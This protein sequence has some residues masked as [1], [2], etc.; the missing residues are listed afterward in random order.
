MAPFLDYARR[1]AN[2]QCVFLY[3]HLYPP[4]EQHRGNT[5]TLTA[6]YLIDELDVPRREAATR[7]SRGEQL[8]YR[9]DRNGFHVFGYAGMTT[10][11]HFEHFYAASDLLKLTSL[12]DAQ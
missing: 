12:D 1:A 4:E 9:A 11:D 3:S 7:N 2:G 8:L 5:T 10:Q 6:S